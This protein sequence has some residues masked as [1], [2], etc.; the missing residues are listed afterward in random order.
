M[1]G[2]E[3]RKEGRREGRVYPITLG[4]PLIEKC[5]C[6][7][8]H[9]THIHVQ[10]NEDMPYCPSWYFVCVHFLNQNKTVFIVND[11]RL[12]GFCSFPPGKELIK[13]MAVLTNLRKAANHPLLLRNHYSNDIIAKMSID[14]LKVNGLTCTCILL[15]A[16]SS[17]NMYMYVHIL[18]TCMHI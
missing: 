4:P 1:G 18:P 12:Q 17:T 8:M 6:I 16:C 9:Q 2:R 7:Y 3:G 13:S 14:I 5:T 15:K 10:R 11:D